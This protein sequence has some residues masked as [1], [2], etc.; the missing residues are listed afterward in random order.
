[1]NFLVDKFHIGNHTMP[2]CQDQTN[3]F[4]YPEINNINTVIC[5]QT[6][7]KL[8]KCGNLGFKSECYVYFK[9]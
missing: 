7:L 2:L 5:E 1:M 9:K 3:P 6:N 8:N 4:K